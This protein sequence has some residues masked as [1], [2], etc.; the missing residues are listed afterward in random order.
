MSKKAH[1]K[2]PTYCPFGEDGSHMDISKRGRVIQG[3]HLDNYVALLRWK[4]DINFL[5]QNIS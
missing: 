1:K 5:G 4:Q 3:K 2:F